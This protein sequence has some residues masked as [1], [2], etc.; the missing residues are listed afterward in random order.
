M[1][2][3]R[4]KV[5]RIDW[6]AFGNYEQ[7]N[8]EPICRHFFPLGK[9]FG[10][11]WKLGDTTGAAG[12]SLGVE[13]DGDRAGLWQDRATGEKGRL[14]NLIATKGGISD[15]AAVEEVERAFG[16]TFRENGSRN[17]ATSPQFDW[18]ACVM[19]MASE[20]TILRELATWR[21]FSDEFCSWLVAHK[22]LELF[23]GAIAFPIH[24]Q[25]GKVVGPHYLLSREQKSWRYTAGTKVSALILGDPRIA[26]EF[27]I[28]E[29]TWDGLAYCDRSEAYLSSHVC[30]IITRG[31]G[32]ART[33][34]ELIA[35]GKK[36]YVWP[37]NDKPDEKTGKVA[38]E[39]WFNAIADNLEGSFL[40]S[41]D[42]G[43]I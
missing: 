21:G 36:T 7:Q 12:N 10:H 35:A 19:A 34:R 38:S 1:P 9:K 16:A 17:G 29:S 25:A 27:H 15:Q 8:A 22:L 14:R 20:R 31:A 42:A 33:V 2:E 4:I 13:L 37:Q 32:H 6:Q 28:H 40:S 43:R 11:E 24:D 30:V 41:P 26:T 39:E 3:A 23:R 18:N 5:D